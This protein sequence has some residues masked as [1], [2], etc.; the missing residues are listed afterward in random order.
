MHQLLS[1]M[2]GTA[3]PLDQV[4]DS[5]F[6]RKLLGDGVA[7]LPEEGLIL[8]P[9]NGCLSAI[10]HTLHAYIFSTDD[11]LEILVHV[12]L[13]SVGL[14]G[15]GF[16]PL[17]EAGTAVQAGQPVADIDLML[18]R[19]KGVPLYTPVVI[20]EGAEKMAMEAFCGPV[21]AGKTP[22]ITLNP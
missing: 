1:P 16:Y 17:V 19:K 14:Q 7:I 13:Q 12:G 8:S 11:G 15:R 2:T 18:L 3:I 21:E 6:S 20:C 22:L 4:P 9:V 10:S 5:A